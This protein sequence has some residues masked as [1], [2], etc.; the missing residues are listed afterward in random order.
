MN[1][2]F[3]KLKFLSVLMV[4][5]LTL[6][7][8]AGV[9][10]GEENNN[11]DEEQVLRLA[12]EDRYAT[13]VEIA[14]EAFPEG[15]N[16]VI[17]ARGDV[18]IDALAGSFLAGAA[19]APL[20]LTRT[21][22]LP[23]VTAQALEELEA[24]K[25]IILGG[26]S[27][28]SEDVNEELIDMEMDTVRVGGEDRFDTAVQ[29]MEYG[30]ENFEIGDP[31]GAIII[32]G[33]APSDALAAGTWANE[34]QV[35]ILMVQT[36]SLPEV[37]EGAL[38]GLEWVNI[39]GGT[40]VVS[41]G[42]ED[43][44]TMEVTRYAGANRYETSVE[45]ARG[46]YPDARNFAL[47]NGMEG[48][49][50]ALA[51]SVL[52]IPLLYSGQEECPGVVADYIEEILEEDSKVFL[53]GGTAVISGQ[54]EESM[55]D[56]FLPEIVSDVCPENSYVTTEDLE[57]GSGISTLTVQDSLGDGITGFG[58]EDIEVLTEKVPDAT[59]IT[60]AEVNESPYVTI[61]DFTD[62]GDGTYT[63]MIE[64]P[65]GTVVLSIKVDGVIIQTGLEFKITQDGSEVS[66]ENSYV[67]SEDQEDG[68]ALVTLKVRNGLGN[69]IEGF[70]MEDI[71]MG[72]EPDP[73]WASLTDIHLNPDQ[74]T[75]EDFTD[76]GD[77][78]YTYRVVR[79]DGVVTVSI[80]V[81]E[82]IIETGLEIQ[83]TG[84]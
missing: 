55:K 69:V 30:F 62:H 58:M 19:E 12:G 48:L 77:G 66:P 43:A 6:S 1:K 33:H 51:G 18:Y 3:R 29:I 2:S 15:A 8:M 76:Q 27:A 22:S 4:L 21:H 39:I 23:Q 70:G 81:Q 32:N 11:N 57:D 83:V 47:V 41:Q 74:P 28:V 75:I 54:L 36:D 10:Y 20:L 25:A 59:W 80:R 26:E 9:V 65:I 49:V 71:E 24:E 50:D 61:S 38:E 56:L 52:N 84:N 53:L 37:T 31:E 73:L 42:L 45:V 44:M 14:R 35:P 34:N 63:Y 13:A 72:I 79:E 17:I 60:L 82:V 16:Y 64:R 5:A 40:A 78:T 46:L 67:T 7:L 68:S